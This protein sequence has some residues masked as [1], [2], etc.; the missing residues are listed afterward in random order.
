M[1]RYGKSAVSRNTV[2]RRLRELARLDLLPMLAARPALDV[3]I[4]AT[5]SAYGASYDVLRASL[6]KAGAQ[7]PAPLAPPLPVQPSSQDT[8]GT[9]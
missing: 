5:P 8:E 4:R 7:L 6:L 2:K 3:V 1:P 9:P